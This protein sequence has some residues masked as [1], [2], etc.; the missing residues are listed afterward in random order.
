M[1]SISVT[2]NGPVTVM[3]LM[4][5]ETVS[6]LLNGQRG[7]HSSTQACNQESSVFY[8]ELFKP[9]GQKGQQ[10]CR[11]D[12]YGTRCVFGPCFLTF[13]LTALKIF[14]SLLLHPYANFF[15]LYFRSLSDDWE[16]YIGDT[17][18]WQSQ[19]VH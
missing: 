19:I 10:M 9:R 13:L 2:S 3:I 12:D 16:P 7:Q 17:S 11:N 14:Q 8:L 1:G 5:R 4:L 15:T 18:T 6:F